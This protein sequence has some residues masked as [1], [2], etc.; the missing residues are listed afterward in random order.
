MFQHGAM[1]V[2]G[3]PNESSSVVFRMCSIGL[4]N[5]ENVLIAAELGYVMGGTFTSLSGFCERQKNVSVGKVQIL[6]LAQL[7][8]S[9]GFQF[10]NL[11]QPPQKECMQYKIDIGGVEVPR[12]GFLVRWNEAI[13]R[14]PIELGVFLRYDGSLF[15]L[16]RLDESEINLA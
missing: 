1:V 5:E 2:E 4:Y 3:L 7:L 10:L 13:E 16:F 12:S 9:S 8:S 15:D 11:G 14:N 6:A